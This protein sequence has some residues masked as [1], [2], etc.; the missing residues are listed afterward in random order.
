L[1]PAGS[2][3]GG[4]AAGLLRYISPEIAVGRCVL[5]LFGRLLDPLRGFLGAAGTPVV[6][7]VCHSGRLLFMLIL[8]SYQVP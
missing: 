4:L 8:K 6:W 5:Q 2:S 1:L 3:H 7:L